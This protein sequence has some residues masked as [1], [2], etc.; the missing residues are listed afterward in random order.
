MSV[1]PKQVAIIGGAFDP[2]TR[3]HAQIA[4]LVISA[5]IGIDEVWFMPCYR[6]AFDKRMESSG[7]RLA[8]CRIASKAIP[9][10]KVCDYEIRKRFVG[11]TYFLMRDLLEEDFVKGKCELSLVIGMD[12]AN[13]FQTWIEHERLARLVR[14]IVVPRKG[15]EQDSASAWY[16]TR[17]H[18]YVD[19]T[20]TIMEVSSTQVRSLLAG[21]AH[22]QAS[23]LLD[24]GVLAYAV[25]HGLY[26]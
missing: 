19:S 15:Y 23:R 11:G 4:G 20:D 16:M 8:M 9:Q 13:C 6:H 25:E 10:A 17:P 22:E 3:G 12:N 18:I 21:N 2:I 5:G 7:H 26:A 24:P 1:N 14:F